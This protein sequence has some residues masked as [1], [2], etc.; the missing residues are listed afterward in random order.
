MDSVAEGYA[1]SGGLGK[2]YATMFFGI[3][4]V[5]GSLEYIN[6]GHP[7]PLLLR[8]DE[9]GELHTG[10]SLPLGLFPEAQHTIRQAKLMPGDTLVLFSDGVTEAED[11]SGKLFGVARLQDVLAGHHASPL[12]ELKQSI[13]KAVEGFSA[14]TSQADDLTLLLVRYNGIPESDRTIATVATATHLTRGQA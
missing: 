10:G 4:D 11:V 12:D 9:V 5:D 2:R 13:V 14:G 8:K 6:A 3:L 1:T 7:S